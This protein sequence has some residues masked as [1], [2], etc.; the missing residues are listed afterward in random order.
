MEKIIFDITAIQRLRAKAEAEPL[1]YVVATRFLKADYSRFGKWLSDEYGLFI[2]PCY[3]VIY[4][5][6]IKDFTRSGQLSISSLMPR[7]LP[8]TID[9]VEEISKQF[10]MGDRTE[11]SDHQPSETGKHAYFVSKNL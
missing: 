11:W 7:L 3:H 1:D 8:V 10:S 2:P 5:I 4:T 9:I 6:E